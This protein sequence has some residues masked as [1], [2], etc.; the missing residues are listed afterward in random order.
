M[1]QMIVSLKTV[2]FFTY[3]TFD[4]DPIYQNF[5]VWQILIF[6]SAVITFSDNYQHT[7]N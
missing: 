5:Y 6:V 1:F 4:Y 7:K 2:I 3:A